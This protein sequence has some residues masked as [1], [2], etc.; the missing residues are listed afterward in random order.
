M[1]TEV[2]MPKLGLTMEKGTIGAWLAAEGD[3]VEK[4]KP[5]LEVVTDKVTMEVEAQASGVLRKVLVEAGVEVDV[6]TPIGVIAGAE[7]DID[8]MLAAYEAGAEAAPSP[9]AEP[10]TAPLPAASAPPV[11]APLPQ[12]ASTSPVPAAPPASP[13][14]RESN[15]RP[16]RAS[17]KA[18]KMAAE[19]GV[20]LS[21]IQGSGPGGRIVSADLTA[22]GAAAPLPVHPLQPS[23]AP[24]PPQ[25]QWPATAPAVAP[26]E[27]TVVALTRPQQIAAER[28]TAS[29]RDVPHIHVW[30]EISAVW[31]QQFRQGYSLEGKKI[32]YNDL[33]VKAVARTLTEFP[34]FNAAFENGAVRQLGEVNI[35][36]AADTPQGL[37]VPVLRN[38]A[39]LTVEQISQETARL[40]DG[41]RQGGLS[42]DELSGGTFTI[43]NLGM[44][45]VSRFTAI[46][47]PPQVAILAVGAV[48][49]RVVALENDALAVRPY[50]SV[51]LAADHRALDG[52]MCARFLRRLKEV[53]ETPGLLA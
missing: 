32:S 50:M 24:V 33:V 9:P 23:A 42:L 29:S 43:S 4:G 7:E 35:G 41:A 31:L 2:V 22:P 37:L 19:L 34:R 12:P 26:L 3:E 46:I 13:Q 45:G 27:E 40:V 1:A 39:S 44:F 11:S 17:P 51:D 21:R 10:E 47:N 52:A 49:K 20:D 30:M 15:G 16:H 14:I 28:L 5:I 53:I 38:A 6:S 36:I 48:E 8:D 18:R 25:P